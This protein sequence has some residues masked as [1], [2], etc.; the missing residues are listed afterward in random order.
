MSCRVV[1]IFHILFIVFFIFY[2][3]LFIVFS[4]IVS[5]Y[6]Y[7]LFVFLFIFFY[8]ICCILFIVFI[9]S[10]F[11]ICRFYVYVPFCISIGLNARSFGLNFGP[12]WHKARPKPTARRGPG[13]LAWPFSPF[14]RVAR[15]RP[16]LLLSSQVRT[17]D[18]L[19]LF[20]CATGPHGRHASSFFPSASLSARHSQLFSIFFLRN[21]V[22][23][24]LWLAYLTAPGSTL[25]PADL[26]HAPSCK[27]SF[28]A[29]PHPRDNSALSQQITACCFS[30]QNS[31]VYMQAH[32]GLFTSPVCTIK[33]AVGFMKG[34]STILQK[35][36]ERQK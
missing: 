2:F 15:T 34:G 8:F 14:S 3:L 9:L 7:F 6:Y 22:A 16:G 33:G 36:E 31:Q 4:F 10:L 25:C 35:R 27:I 12:N 30:R 24:L 11:F 28:H 23:H 19:S 13:R 21:D 20:G 5:F 18:L 17:A 29:M 26:D 32:E 1:F